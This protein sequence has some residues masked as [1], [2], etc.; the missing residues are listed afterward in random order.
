ML[1]LFEAYLTCLERLHADLRSVLEG[2]P[3]E[4]LDWVPPGPEMNSLAVLAAHITGSERYWVGEIAGGDPAHRDRSAEFRTE[5][6]D[7]TAL[8][9]GLEASLAH[10]RATLAQLTLADLE[11]RRP[12]VDRDEVTVAWAL[13]HSLQH[14]ATH[15]GQMQMTRQMWEQK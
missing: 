14:I 7:G 12:A 6:V 13:F 4:G 11:T 3:Q 2:V 5:K 1:P 9:A 10:S 15:L 8:L